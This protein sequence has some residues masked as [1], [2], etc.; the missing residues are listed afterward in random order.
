M[1]KALTKKQPMS[2]V[3]R[4]LT[5]GA[6]EAMESALTPNREE[7]REPLI[8]LKQ[9]EVIVQTKN[10]SEIPR[11]VA[12]TI[13]PT[14]TINEQTG[15]KSTVKS[16]VISREINFSKSADRLLDGLVTTFKNSTMT[17]ITRSHLIRG[18]L[19]IVEDKKENIEN[20][21]FEAGELKRPSNN[22]DRERDHFDS[23]IAGIIRK[24]LR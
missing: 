3:D 8:E 4:F 11:K 14:K 12:G 15:T 21:I 16:S 9:Q 6:M 22:D 2:S 1:A 24:G 17:P 20:A 5:F 7:K 13:A 23:V 19:K 18:L 10:I